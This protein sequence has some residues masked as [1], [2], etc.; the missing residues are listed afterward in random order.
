MKNIIWLAGLAV[1]AV[2]ATGCA[3][4]PESLA[5]GSDD[6]LTQ[7]VGEGLVT[8]S[9]D[10]ELPVTG[11]SRSITEAVAID[12]AT[13]AVA[14]SPSCPV[15][16]PSAL[17]METALPMAGCVRG[18]LLASDAGRHFILR[19]MA[20]GSYRIAVTHAVD[21]RFDLGQVTTTEG[22]TACAP[23]AT[24]LVSTR[25]TVEGTPGALCVVV[26]SDSGEAQP[27][28]LIAE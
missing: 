7:V 10:R 20:G 12:D 23:F 16:P 19:P 17:T 18:S 14:A 26:R 24:G 22:V 25:L 21:A 6:A 5:M 9:A 1:A 15:A 3:G 13:A 2:V 11:V 4:G 28:R 8:L 27:F